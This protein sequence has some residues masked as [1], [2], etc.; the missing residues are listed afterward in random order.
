[1]L[2]VCN[3]PDSVGEVLAQWH[4]QIDP[5]R[6]ERVAALVPHRP[7]PGRQALKSDPTYLA[8]LQSIAYL[9]A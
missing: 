5:V 1:M 6:G 9:A 3:S 8:A 7:P 4:P 2:L